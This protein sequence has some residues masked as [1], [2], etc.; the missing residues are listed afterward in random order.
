[1]FCFVDIIKQNIW[2]LAKYLDT[3][4]TKDQQKNYILSNLYKILN[5]LLDVSN[6]WMDDP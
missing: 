6:G 5:T 1:M 2:Y 4:T 3:T